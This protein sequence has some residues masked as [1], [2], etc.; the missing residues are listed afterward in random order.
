MN[1]ATR[2]RC[3]TREYFGRCADLRDPAFHEDCHPIGDRHRFFL[4][5]RDVDGRDA[6]RALQLAQLDA[7]LE[8]QFRVEVR[9][10]LVEQEQA[11]LTN[12]RARQR[13]AL[14]LSAGKLA[15]PPL[16]Q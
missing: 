6:E 3:R 5:V 10:R 13:A 4:V 9:Q 16:E 15:G 11:R 14:L 8:P 1:A 2:S 7:R 12:D